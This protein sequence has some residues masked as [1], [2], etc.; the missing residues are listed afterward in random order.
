MTSA[1]DC[2][3]AARAEAPRAIVSV[4]TASC[5]FFSWLNGVAKVWKTSYNGQAFHLTRRVLKGLPRRCPADRVD[6]GSA[7]PPRLCSVSW[8][9]HRLITPCTR[10]VGAFIL[11]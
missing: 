3:T 5:A 2:A 9:N 7:P 8:F 10:F 1:V 4:R 6:D 11:P